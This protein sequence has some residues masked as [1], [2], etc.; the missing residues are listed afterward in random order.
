[1]MPEQ[2][3]RMQSLRMIECQKNSQVADECIDPER[4]NDGP[5]VD[6]DVAIVG[7]SGKGENNSQ[8]S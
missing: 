6:V 5:R 2:T 8:M 4:I 1:M 3:Q 7:Q